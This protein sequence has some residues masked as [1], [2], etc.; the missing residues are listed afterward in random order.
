MYAQLCCMPHLQCLI[1]DS[2]LGKACRH[3]QLLNNLVALLSSLTRLQVCGCSR[4][5]AYDGFSSF[6]AEE[7]HA[8]SLFIR[9]VRRLTKLQIL[10]LHTNMLVDGEGQAALRDALANMQQLRRLNLTEQLF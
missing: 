4:S 3:E 5:E 7:E 10:V 9:C 2:F 1:I 8:A 6:L